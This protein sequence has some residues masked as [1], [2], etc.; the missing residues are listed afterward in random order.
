LKTRGLLVCFYFFS[1]VGLVGCGDSTSE[2][3]KALLTD[4]NNVRDLMAKNVDTP[5]EGMK[6][7]RA[8]AQDHLP[9]FVRNVTQLYVDID[10]I[11]APEDRAKR[12]KQIIEELKPALKSLSE[13]GNKFSNKA[14]TD[15]KAMELQ[16][17]WA[18]DWQATFK[19]IGT[20]MQGFSL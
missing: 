14:A 12:V 4:L 7:L 17:Q 16:Q 10:K 15:P 2:L 5:A 8:Y 13:Q 19:E 3:T 1:L 18:K 11:P 9:N 20:L 6:L